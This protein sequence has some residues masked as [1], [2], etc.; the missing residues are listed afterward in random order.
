MLLFWEG[1]V[2]TAGTQEGDEDD[3]EPLNAEFV[4]WSNGTVLRKGSAPT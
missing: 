4:A 1:F 2:Y 3:S